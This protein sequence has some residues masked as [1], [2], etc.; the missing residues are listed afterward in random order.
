M[1]K[2]ELLVM[3]RETAKKVRYWKRKAKNIMSH[4][5]TKQKKK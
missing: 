3:V 4:H 2:P 5:Q 1:T